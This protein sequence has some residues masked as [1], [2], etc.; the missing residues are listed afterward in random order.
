MFAVLRGRMCLMKG[1]DSFSLFYFAVKPAGL[2]KYKKERW[3]KKNEQQTKKAFSR[4]EKR[5]NETTNFKKG[6]T[7]RSEIPA[8]GYAP[9]NGISEA[10]QRTGC[11]IC[12]QQ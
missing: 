2:W 3:F 12:L 6:E 11:L 7:K 10:E 1:L 4:K 8:Y 9:S 5:K